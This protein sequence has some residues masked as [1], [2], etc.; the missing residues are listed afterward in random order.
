M[1][2]SDKHPCSDE[3][4][5][6]F[7]TESD[8]PFVCLHWE[9]NA[10]AIDKWGQVAKDELEEESVI[11]PYREFLDFDEAT[12]LSDHFD[13]ESNEWIGPTVDIEVRVDNEPIKTFTAYPH[14]GGRFPGFESVKLYAEG[15]AEGVLDAITT[16]AK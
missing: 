3:Q 13:T 1:S 11:R 9:T 7:I 14:G 5:A 4:C 8:D 6:E 10:E 2:V 16:R 12:S 15:Y